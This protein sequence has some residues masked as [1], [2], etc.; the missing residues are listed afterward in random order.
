MGD[1]MAGASGTQ[2][3]LLTVAVAREIDG[4][5][6]GV[7]SDGRSYLTARGLARLC[8]VA[9]SA[10]ITQGANWKRG[11]RDGKLAAWLR[12][13]GIEQDSL[14]VESQVAG[15][16][17]HAYTDDVAMLILEYYAYEAGR[18][19]E[20]VQQRF[21]TLARA[22][23]RLF[24]YGHVGYD[25][26]RAVPDIWRQFHDRVTLVT[27]PQGYFSVFRE[28]S[29]IVVSAIRGGLPVDNHTVPDIS[30]GRTWGDHWTENDLGAEHG[31]RI[32][33]PHN[34]PDYFPQSASNPQEMWVYPNAALPTFRSWMQETYVAAKLPA[35]LDRK[36]KSGVLPGSVARTLLLE[37]TAPAPGLPS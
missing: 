30:V 11:H 32:K 35:Y 29:D 20:L 26:A 14:Y 4:I 34:Y 7:L 15:T 10:I 3:T 22:G 5:E 28:M 24:V 36:V 33:H 23:L 17:V 31:D 27:A 13:H 19:D 25:P 9:P 2:L 18:R 21:R 6:M 12:G 1:Q 8:G 16:K 37:A